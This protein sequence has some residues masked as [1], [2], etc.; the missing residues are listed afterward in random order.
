MNWIP[1]DRE[2][3][4][5]DQTVLLSCP[6]ESEPVQAGFFDS[7]FGVFRNLHMEIVIVSHWQPMPEPAGGAA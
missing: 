3:P 1:C 5:T 6:T 4:D 2:M 7:E